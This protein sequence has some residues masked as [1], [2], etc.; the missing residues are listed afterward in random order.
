M[1]D[2]MYRQEYETDFNA[3]NVGSIFGRWMEKVEK[4]GRI[5]DEIDPITPLD[6]LVMS[7]DIG[8]RD[9]AAFWWWRIVR[10]GFELVHFDQASGLDAEEWI[11]RLSTQPRVKTLWLPH[12]ARTKTFQTRHSVIE[13]FISSGIAPDIRIV[14]MTKKKDQ[15]NAGRKV[16]PHCRF[17]KTVCEEGTDALLAYHYKYD[18]EQKIF[19][20]EPDHDWASHASDAFMY[21]AQ[22]MEDYVPKKPANDSLIIVPQMPFG[23]VKLDELWPQIQSMSRRI[24]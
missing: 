16:L 3:A 10:G 1:P 6:E 18:E 9:R 11:D 14:P 20:Q 23:G 17:A 15:I 5:L 8:R 19:S 13:Q 24:Q 2:E 7:S 12:D 4:E 22:M 21:G